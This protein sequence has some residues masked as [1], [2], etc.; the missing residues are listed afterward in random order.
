MDFNLIQNSA[1][2]IA[3][4]NELLALNPVT[5]RYGLSLTE[6]DAQAL[7]AARAQALKDT[8]RVALGKSAMPQLIYAFCDSPYLDQQEYAQQ[9]MALQSTFYALKSDLEGALSDE[10]LIKA[11]QTIFNGSAQGS[12]EELCDLSAGEL[13]RVTRES[14]Y[15]EYREE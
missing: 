11:M 12:I 2:L 8:G 14:R 10:E 9:L 13:L 1:G 15:G 6:K 5:E 3:A 7:V 4:Q